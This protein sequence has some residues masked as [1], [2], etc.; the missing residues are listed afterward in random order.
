MIE[1][2]AEDD[3]DEGRIKF[4]LIISDDGETFFKYWLEAYISKVKGQE[5]FPIMLMRQRKNK[6]G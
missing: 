2:G 6:H 5:R 1:K 4:F 3:D